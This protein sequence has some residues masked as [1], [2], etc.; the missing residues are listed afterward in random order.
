MSNPHLEDAYPLTPMQEGM[1]FHALLAPGSDVDL[2]QYVFTLRGRVDAPALRRAWERVLDRHSVLRTGFE[3]GEGERP[4]QV[5]HRSV[6]LPWEEADWRGLSAG[7]QHERLAALLRSDRSRGFDPSRAPLLRVALARVAESEFRLVW[8]HHHLLLDGWS[9]PPV[10]GEVLACYVAGVRGELPVLPARRPFRDFVDW[11]EGQDPEREETFWRAE[12]AGFRAATAVLPERATGEEG[13]GTEEARL[14]A[15]LTAGLRSLGRR[16]GLTLGTLVQGAWALL[17]SSYAGEDDVVFGTV[18]SGRPAELEGVEEMV[19]M[20]VNTI[21]ARARLAPGLAAADWLGGLQS[22]AAAAREHEHAPLAEVQRWSEVPPG[23]PL[24]RSLLAFENYVVEDV[25]GAGGVGLVVEV[26]EIASRTSVPLAL[27]VTPG[28]R[29]GVRARFDRA[30]LE[31]DAVERM[32]GHLSALLAGIARAPESF[33]SDL[34][35]LGDDERRQV[36][37]EWNRTGAD[38]P[39]D[40]CVHELFALQAARTPDAPAVM[41]RKERLTFA[42]LHAR[43]ARLAR[44]LGRRG[45]GPEVRVGIC[46]ERGTE[47]VVAILGVLAAGGAYVPLDPAHPTDRLALVL[48]DSG[49]AVLLT[50]ERLLPRLPATAPVTLCVDTLGGGGACGDSTEVRSGVRPENLAYVIYTSGSTGAPKGV[51]VEHRSVVNLGVL[52]QRAVYDQWGG[53]PPPSVSMNGPFTFDTSVKQLVRLLAG[54]TLH[55]IPEEV[56]YDGEA[57]AAYLGEHEVDVLDCTPAQLRLLLDAG[58]LEAPGHPAAVL[59]AGEAIDEGTWQRLGAAEGRSYHNLYGPTECTVD[60][61]LCAVRGSSPTPVIG[62][63]GANVRLYVADPWLRPAPVGIPGELYVGGAGVARG[64]L[65]RPGLTAE[66]FLPDPFGEEPRSGARL[67]RTGDR[68]RWLASGELE[69]LG[70]VDHQVKIRGFRIEP[71]EV[72]AALARS[73]LVGEAAVVAREDVPGELRLVGYV[74]GRGGEAPDV[75]ALRAGLRAALPEYMVPSAIV[76]LDALPRTPHGKLDRAALP[77]PERRPGGEVGHVPPRTPVE[78]S[79]AAIWEEVLKVGPVGAGDDFFALGGHSLHAARVAS[80][81]RA[82]LGVEVPLRACFEA[83]TLAELAGAV[84]AAMRGAPGEPPPPPPLV[85]VPRDRDLPLSFAQQRLWYLDQL[86]PGSAAYTMATALRLRGELSHAALRRSLGDLVRRHEVLRTTFPAPGGKPV[87]R[88]AA[89]GPVP[90]PEVD[91]RALEPAARGAE[92]RRLARDEATRPFDLE[93][94]PLLRAVLAR[95]GESDRAVLFTLHHVVSD[96]WSTAILVRE[97][98]RLYTARLEG[99]EPGLPGLPVQYADFAVWQ[100]EWLRG[101]TLERQLAYW[102][103]RLAGAPP[104]LELPTDRPRPLV[105]SPAGASVPFELAPEVVRALRPLARHEGATPFMVLLASWTALLA[106]YVGEEDVLVGTPVAGRGRVEVEGLIGFFVNTLVIRADLSG[107][108]GFLALLGRVRARVLE[109]HA[110]QDLPFERLIDALGVERSQAHTPLF[111]AMLTLLDAPE[112]EVAPALAGVEVEKLPADGSTAKFDL[113]LSLTD[114]GERLHGELSYRAE[115]WDRATVERML[116]HLAALLAGVVAEPEGAVDAV[117]LLGEAERERLLVEWNDT[118]RAY[119]PGCV[120][121]LFAAQARRTP[122]R[123]A[124]VHDEQGV[125][126]AALERRANQLAHRLRRMGVGPEVCVG[127]CLARTPALLVALLAVHRA[128]GAYVPLDPAYPRERIGYMVGDAGIRLVLADEARRGGLPEGVEVLA[129][130]REEDAI[131]RESGDEPESGVLPENLSHVIFTSGSTGRPKGVMIRHSSAVVL[132]H[133]M[134]ENVSDGERA[135]VLGSTSTSFDVSVAEIFGALCWGGTLV[136]AEN[137]LAL[138]ELGDG[139]IRYASMTP[140]AAAELLRAGALPASLRTIFLAGEPLPAPLAGKLYEHG[141]ARVANL[142]GPTE[143]TSYSTYALVPRGADR[144]HI[145]RP[146]VNTRAYVLDAQ[147]EPSPVGIPGELYL[148]GDGLAR[149]YVSRPELTADRFLPDPFGAPGSR[150]YRT[151]DRVRQGLDG[152]L[153]YLGRVDSQVKLRGF[154]IELGEVETVLRRHRAVH[155]AV[156]VV[157]EDAP[158]DRRLVAYVT[159]AGEGETPSELRAHL[160][161]HLPEYM[162]P[163]AVMVM[164]RLPLTPSGKIDRRALPEPEWRDDDREYEAPRTPVERVLAGVWA[165]VLRVSRVGV[166]DR[167][168]DLGGDS[169]LSIQAVA[170]ARREGVNLTPRQMVEHP[171]IAGLARVAGGAPAAAGEEA[172][173]AGELPLTPIQRWFFEQETGDPHHWNQAFLV[174]PRRRLDPGPLSRALLRLTEHHDALRLRFSHGPG[175]WTQRYA[176]PGGS[177]PLL[178]VDLSRLPQPERAPRME[179]ASAALQASLDVER[180]PLL[181]A[182][183]FDLGA[184]GERLLLVVHHLAVDGVSWRVLLE[185]LQRLYEQAARGERWSLPP[186]TTPFGRWA[187]LLAE[188]AGSGELRAEAGHW[189]ALTRTNVPRLPVELPGRE[190]RSGSVRYVSVA[191]DAEET[192]ALLQEVPAAYRTQVNDVLLAALARTLAWWTGERRVLLHLEGHGRED[193][194]PGVDLSRT[195]GWFTALFPVLLD[196]SDAWGDAEELKAVKEQLRAVPAHGIGYGIL[197]YLAPEDEGRSELQRIPQPEISFNYLGQF[198]GTVAGEA[199]FALAHEPMGPSHAPGGRR[200]HLLDVNAAVEDGILRVRWS[201]SRDLHRPETVEALAERYA[202]ELRALVE[203]CCSPDAGGCTPSDF[204]LA[205]LD[206]ATLAML[207]ADLFP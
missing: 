110:R 171:T 15:V 71:G 120:H 46:V 154:R 203:H 70:R 170:R 149:G 161:Q 138:A 48:A 204:P 128:G 182:A 156:A 117:P 113:T 145:G 51:L 30:R 191:L 32:L 150:M 54:S 81:I 18:V 97:V 41:Y 166:N 100:R 114:T 198:D 92:L 42:E 112:G 122:G 8:T 168:F 193:L 35:L 68:V 98:S 21:P 121:D 140:S 181:R 186:G 187:E 199:L 119:L 67:Y 73:P 79:L 17:L 179:A 137:A 157:R 63:P 178:A 104:L 47:L 14:P 118:R 190:N 94:G 43:S 25:L 129:L 75:E 74:A 107:R 180:G 84:D 16:Y 60:A 115:L 116:G 37:V 24:F 143:D 165:E 147:L 77:A 194:F 164:E 123:D 99:R 4:R 33:L 205:Q 152:V 90:L 23:E 83:R 183:R 49:A 136:L 26:E 62:R 91:L 29:L 206:E 174:A 148:A 132:L 58:M 11:L 38:H 45:V 95:L 52:L 55:V 72:E 19:G 125:S 31:G 44:E 207:E 184:A 86:E 28:A 93:R 27:V 162:V 9:A 175:G 124:V 109:A 173:P 141:V 108:P 13:Q 20:F 1:L 101:E 177:S 192:R 153:D 146:L 202:A 176:E 82:A 89:P 85:P 10:I 57:L 40:L 130:D 34:P 126:Y 59:V 151:K 36:L 50:Q 3:R 22:R 139:G 159:P 88:I 66:R 103:E 197:R 158:G 134:R 189:G 195:V 135:V 65:G 155:D 5:V 185:D 12:L 39:R 169:I 172:L 53:G 111:Q 201:Y 200:A 196:L 167:F 133:W 69:F 61:A 96:G 188:Y 142:Y 163:A 7:E 127:V 102:R 131:G 106:R 64:Y 105:Q 144:I 80:R 2:V 160:R 76:V 6:Q 87:Q 78:A 56:R